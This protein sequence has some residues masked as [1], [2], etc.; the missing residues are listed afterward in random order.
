MP[1]NLQSSI[2]K[3]NIT[4]E[5]LNLLTEGEIPE[6]CQ[7]L[8]LFGPTADISQNE[9]DIIETY[10]EQGGKMMLVTDC[11]NE[12]LE[13]LCSLMENYGVELVDGMIVEGDSNHFAQGYAKYLVPELESHEITDPLIENNYNVLIPIAQGLRIT[14]DGEE[15]TEEEDSGLT[16]SPL[17]MTT[18]QAFSKAE[19]LDAENAE[20]EDGDIESE[21]GFALGVAITKTQDEG[22]TNIVWFTSTYIVDQQVDTL[23]AGGNSDLLTNSFGWLCGMEDS[24]TI[25]AKAIEAGY[26]TLTAAQTGRW[27]FIFIA[28]IP[29]AFLITGV[30][31]WLKRRKK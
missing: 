24:I 9:A 11:L 1:S 7:C 26:L 31:V 25:H 22:E 12:R 19:G 3:E 21:D 28:V 13:N 23:V 4:T 27:S 15:E 8:I 17:L 20:K 14:A 29:L 10:L 30:V 2:E 5:S 18:D 16:V 6:D